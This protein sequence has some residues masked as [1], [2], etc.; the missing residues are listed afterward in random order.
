MFRAVS[1][2]V[3][4][5]ETLLSPTPNDPVVLMLSR[6]AA[7]YRFTAKALQHAV[8][9]VTVERLRSVTAADVQRVARR[10]FGGRQYSLAV[11]GPSAPADRLDAI[12]AGG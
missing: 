10:V 12:L 9:D 3:S 4:P 5:F 8:P 11:V 2:K 6:G 1:T 7:G